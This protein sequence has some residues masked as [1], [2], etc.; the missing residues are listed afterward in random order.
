MGRGETGFLVAYARIPLA[1]AR[2]ATA[3]VL[4]FA[5]TFRYASVGMFHLTESIYFF[6]PSGGLLFFRGPTAKLP[7]EVLKEEPGCAMEISTCVETQ[8]NEL[9][10][11]P[12]PLCHP[13]R[14][15]GA[16]PFR[17]AD[18]TPHATISLQA[19]RMLPCG[20]CFFFYWKCLL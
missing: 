14:N 20:C 17:S 13:R 15:V 7:A 6:F 4:L 11:S 12:H 2:T 3:E 5:L 9:L 1:D 18:P 10:T 19:I 16:L 8:R